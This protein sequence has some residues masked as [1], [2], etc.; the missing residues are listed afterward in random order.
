MYDNMIITAR[1]SLQHK[2]ANTKREEIVLT[3]YT[4]NFICEKFAT[5]NY[6]II[7]L[8]IFHF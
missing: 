2:Q 1:L 6:H 4:W 7:T 5:S 8:I 3:K